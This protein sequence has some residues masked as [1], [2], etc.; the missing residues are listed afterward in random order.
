MYADLSLDHKILKDIV[1][2]AVKPA[3]RR[4]RVDY[5]KTAYPVSL[6]R[7]CRVVGI[8]GSVYRYPPNTA[9]NDAIIAGLQQ[10]VEKYP[11]YVFKTL[12]VVRATTEEWMDEYNEERPHDTLEDLTPFEYKM[13]HQQWENSTLDCP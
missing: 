1:K 13:A 7:A 2:K 4:E 8:R 9:R 5:A 3:A 10:A 11:A 6:R 12:S